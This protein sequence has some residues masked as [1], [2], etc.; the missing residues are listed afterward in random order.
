M[1][2]RSSAKNAKSLEFL[3]QNPDP[4]DVKRPKK[5]LNDFPPVVL[6]VAHENNT[7]SARVKPE[8]G[9]PKEIRLA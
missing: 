4:D 3:L 1:D 2:F 5:F 6:E 8:P 7:D 9:A